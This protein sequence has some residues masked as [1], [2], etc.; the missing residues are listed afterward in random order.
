MS[1]TDIKNWDQR[2]KD[3][4]L[5][6]W[7]NYVCRRIDL[8]AARALEFWGVTGEFIYVQDSSS[9]SAA[10]AIRINRNTNDQIDLVPGT[11]IKT[12]FQ[13]IFIDNDAQPGEWIDLIVGINFEYYNQS[14]SDQII[15]AE[16]QAIVPLTHANPNT[17][18]TPA[19]Q[20]SN[21][22]IIKADINNTQTVWIDFGTAAV[23]S[24][25]MP[26]DPGEWLRVPLSNLD[27]INANFEVGGEN[28]FIAYEV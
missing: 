8:T 10:A 11:T 26:L 19:A 17:N 7:E 21:A 1:D 23:Q 20:I 9:A 28:V 3:Q 12:V 5:R 15:S 18:V 22:A 2:L 27:Q 6:Q 25:C 14:V 4:V 13:T 24:A 16:V